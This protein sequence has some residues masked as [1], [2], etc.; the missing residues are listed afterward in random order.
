MATVVSLAQKIERSDLAS[1]FK[2][3]RLLKQMEN[4]IGDV[5]ETLPEAI[6]Q[7][8]ADVENAQATADLA[9]SNAAAAQADATA[10]LANSAAAQADIDALALRDVPLALTDAATITVDAVAHNSF[11]VTL[12]GNR[13]LAAPSNLANGMLL[14]FAIRQDGTGGRTLAFDAIYDFGDQGTP[15]LSTAASAVDYV[16]GYYDSTSAKILCRFRKSASGTA[17]FS[18]HNNGVN[19][20]LAT[21]TFTKLSM[22]TEAFDI[23]SRFAGGTWTPPAGK[24]VM[25]IGAMAIGTVA[26][27]LTTVLI[28]KN[29]AEYKRGDMQQ[30]QGTGPVVMHVSCIDIPNGTD[31]YELYG[32]QAT[33]VNQNTAGGATVTYF[34]GTTLTT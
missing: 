3:P 1:V 14:N 4:V 15:V 30:A 18:A 25:L 23:G 10:A 11:S 6:D 8:N 17:S 13:T 31:T 21:A 19:Q 32:Y 7:I 27:A 12:G 20:T 9:L 22:S 28:Y 33:G 2:T 26:G 29:G 16:S 34:Q 5:A 24:P